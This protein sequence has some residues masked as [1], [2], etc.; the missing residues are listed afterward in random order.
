MKYLH[1]RFDELPRIMYSHS[2]VLKKLD[3]CKRNNPYYEITFFEEGKYKVRIDGEVFY[4]DANTFIFTPADV[5][6]SISNHGENIRMSC[7]AFFFGPKT[8]IVD[9]SNI[10]FESYDNHFLVRNESVYVPLTG[11]YDPINPSSLILLRRVIE[12]NRKGGRYTNVKCANLIV[13]L[14]L[15]MATS[16]AEQLEKRGKS[17]TE[18][19]S[20]QYYCK[21]IEEYLHNNYSHNIDL[22][23][24]AK[25]VGLHPNYVS[26]VFKQETGSTIM[27]VLRNIRVDQAKKLIFM[28]KYRIKDIAHMVGFL[29]ENYFSSV[30]KRLEGCLPSDYIDYLLKKE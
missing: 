14:I 30:F 22:S 18:I 8:E 23:D 19:P 21:R 29:D 17:D 28:K 12:E 2:C 9:E 15:S 16:V 5:D 1:I 6:Y 4:G 10:V 13:E 11:N 3:T 7:V 27:S 25:H 20:N 26:S 24:V